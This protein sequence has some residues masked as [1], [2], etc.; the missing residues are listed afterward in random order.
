ME[1]VARARSPVSNAAGALVFVGFMGAGKSTAVRTAAAALG[2]EALDSD[3]ELERQFGETIESFFDRE[4]EAAFRARE[5][6]VVLELLGRADARA[7]AL[8]GGAILSERVREAL[9]G[10]TVVHLD[11]EIERAWQRAGGRSRPLARDRDRFEELAR[12]RGELYASVADAHIPVGERD[13]V[14]H[15]LPALLALSEAAG[16]GA[17]LVW[18]SAASGDYPVFFGRGLLEHG[19]MFPTG[20]ERFVVADE[21]VARELAVPPGWG[22]NRERVLAVATGEAQKTLARAEAVLSGLARAGAA[23]D[24]LV[25]AYGGGVVGDLA[26]FCAAVYQRGVA[27]AGVPTTLVAQV[28]S[29][30]GGK[31]GVDLPQA[32]NYVG[33]Y[34]QPAAVVTDPQ[35]LATLPE[36]ER[37]AGYA[38]VVKT[39]LIAGGSLWARVRRGAQDDDDV[40]LDCLRTKLAVVAA[41]ER[42]GGRRQVLNLGHTIGHAIEVATGYERYR[43]GEAI[44]IG[45]LCALRLSGRE[46]LRSE[47]AELLSARGLPLRFEGA[48][49]DDVLAA[50]ELDKKRRG[51]S[52]PFVL[53]EAPGAVTHGHSVDA[54]ELRAAVEE[55]AA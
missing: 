42:D 34:H 18:A 5:E 43:H 41:D 16:A 19:L 21:N 33:A 29:A 27:W 7:V 9:R 13:V 45:L 53:V 26:G 15:A 46:A 37:A 6:E 55:A 14:R 50:L 38:E 48:G 51:G 4:G 31:T 35:A 28:D 39:A 17:Q 44:A 23:G 25:I 22:V 40:I 1:E 36:A 52:V 3:R 30:Y 24:D 12:E 10:H 54:G 32:K 11:I 49:V 8:G 47:V 2:V 20:G